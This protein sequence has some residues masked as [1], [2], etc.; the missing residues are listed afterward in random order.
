MGEAWTL[1]RAQAQAYIADEPRLA[2]LL[3]PAVLAHGSGAQALVALLV[4][5]LG[6][7]DAP[8]TL[9]RE[10]LA[11]AYAADPALYRGSE[12]DLFAIRERDPACACLCSAFLF[13]KGFHALQ[14]HR[15]AH[16]HWRAGQHFAARLLQHRAAEALGIDIHPAAV[17]GSAVMLDHGT[18][19]VAGETVVIGDGVSL[20]HGV[21]LGGTG[22]ETGD[23]HP[24]IRNGVSIGA[25]A[26]VLGNVE[27][28]EG[29]RIGAGSVVL[30]AV[31]A[32]VTAVGARARLVERAPAAAPVAWSAG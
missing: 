12:R 28:G 2:E 3:E 22:K 10:L 20:L 24:R 11:Q 1:I 9:L 7:S 25:G 32:A 8:G 4:A 15:A 17:I 31:P 6:G 5:R 21:T 14:A 13:F 27:V 19:F 30:S 16:W 29:A 23:R 18:G 26:V